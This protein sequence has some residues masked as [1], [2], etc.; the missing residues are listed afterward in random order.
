M[1]LVIEPTGIAHRLLLMVSAP[2]GGLLG[3]AVGTDDTRPL[4]GDLLANLGKIRIIKKLN[5]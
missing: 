5:F 4:L 2:Q 1:Q 3:F